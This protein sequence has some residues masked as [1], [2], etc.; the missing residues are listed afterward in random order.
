[1]CFSYGSSLSLGQQLSWSR[2]PQILPPVHLL[3]YDRSYLQP[4]YYSEYL[5]PQSLQ[6]KWIYNEF[7]IHPRPRPRRGYV[8]FQRLELVP[9]HDRLQYDRIFWRNLTCRQ[10]SK[11]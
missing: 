11:I 4:Y 8:R 6:T 7:H 9:G 5:E 2:E 1:M 10:W 3:P